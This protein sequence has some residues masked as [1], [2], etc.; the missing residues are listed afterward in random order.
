MDP[1]FFSQA[2]PGFQKFWKVFPHTPF[3]KVAG[4]IARDMLKMKSFSVKK[5]FFPQF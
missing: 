1:N 3:T 2:H 5:P 4:L